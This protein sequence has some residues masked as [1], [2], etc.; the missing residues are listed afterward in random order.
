M[1]DG[2]LPGVSMIGYDGSFGMSTFPAESVA[3]FNYRTVQAGFAIPIPAATMRD[4]LNETLASRILNDYLMFVI[5]ILSAIPYC[6]ARHSAESRVARW[7][8]SVYV[9]SPTKM[10][11]VTH[12]FIGDFL[13]MRRES[14]T[15]SLR[16][17]AANGAIETSRGAIT[18]LNPQ[19]LIKKCCSC[20][21][22]DKEWLG[23][24]A[25]SACLSADSGEAA[26]TK[27]PISG[28]G[29]DPLALIKHQS[30]LANIR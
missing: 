13:S 6:V 12:E 1:Q 19:T 24:W 18:V 25:A 3:R 26:A 11:T 8:G 2:A 30:A 10:I 16:S 5:Q 4:I 14:V 27:R 20:C 21:A 17:L 22:T 28:G 9:R 29:G 23:R 15:E 7:I